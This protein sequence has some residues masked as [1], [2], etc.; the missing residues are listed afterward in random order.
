MYVYTS[1]IYFN[2][3]TSFWSF[4]GSSDR[5]IINVWLYFLNYNLIVLD[6]TVILHA[7]KCYIDA[8]NLPFYNWEHLGPGR[9]NRPLQGKS[10][11]QTQCITKAID[12]VNTTCLLTGF[13]I[14]KAQILIL[15]LS[16][17][18]GRLALYPVSNMPNGKKA[19]GCFSELLYCPDGF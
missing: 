16:G 14:W 18:V 4:Y 9:E 8:F 17:N 5:G 2:K 13:S 7:V 3:S 10:P 12:C 6:L 15:G 1:F 19:E 11:S